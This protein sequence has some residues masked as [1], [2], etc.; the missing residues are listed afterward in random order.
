MGMVCTGEHGADP[1]LPEARLTSISLRLI[2]EETGRAGAVLAWDWPAGEKA[3]PLEPG[4][5]ATHFEIY[6][7]LRRDSL[8]SP[9]A[10][11]EFEAGLPPMALVRLPDSA[12]P[13]T[14]YYGVR[15]VLVEPTGQKLFSRTIPVDSLVVNPAQAILSPGTLSYRAGRVLDVAVQTYSDDGIVLRQILYEKKGGNWVQRLDT[16]LPKTA[17]DIPHFS[18]RTHSDALILETLTPTD[19]LECLY[20]VHGDETFEDLDTGRRQS[21]GCIRFFRTGSP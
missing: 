20:C 4:P 7:S 10:L 13:M 16:C 5:E 6:Q 3:N 21:L 2:D 15:A 1:A 18:T 8:G 9:V 17:C 14:V 19:T 12:R 11:V